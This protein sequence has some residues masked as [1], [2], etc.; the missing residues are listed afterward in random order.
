MRTVL[1][2]K[3]YDSLEFGAA[4]RRVKLRCCCAAGERAAGT[5]RDKPAPNDSQPRLWRWHR[6]TASPALRHWVECPW[7]LRARRRIRTARTIAG[8]R[9]GRLCPLASTQGQDKQAL[10]LR[11]CAPWRKESTDPCAK[12]AP[13]DQTRRSIP[14]KCPAEGRSRSP[15]PCTARQALASTPAS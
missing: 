13:P 3:R 5:V 1:A 11:G 6:Y 12:D 10:Y 2:R 14:R 15:S 9:S 4:A 8:R 7:Q